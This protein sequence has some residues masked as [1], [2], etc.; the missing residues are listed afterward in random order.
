MY[1]SRHLMYDIPLPIDECQMENVVLR[2]KR[3]ANSRSEIGDCRRSVDISNTSKELRQSVLGNSYNSNAT[4]QED[5]EKRLST[6]Q[7]PPLFKQLE[8]EG[9]NRA[10]DANLVAD[11]VKSTHC[12]GGFQQFLQR[13]S[14]RRSYKEVTNF[15]RRRNHLPRYSADSG[16][17]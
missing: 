14:T 15:G 1:G 5:V 17:L 7:V 6:R 12:N 13:M 16:I 11:L 3:R 9:E 2:S 4:K 10:T 8:E